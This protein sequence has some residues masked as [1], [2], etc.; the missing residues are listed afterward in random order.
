MP[1]GYLIGGEFLGRIRR[2]VDAADA[3]PYRMSGVKT[4]PRFEGDDGGGAGGG[5]YPVRLGKTTASWTKG[6]TASI[7]LYEEGTPP[8]E[9]KNAENYTLENCVNKFATV[10]SGKWVIVARMTNSR[11]YLIAAEC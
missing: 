1:D 2:V 3:A 9:T 5:G 8:S 6:T 7:E 11:W 10:G 4:Q